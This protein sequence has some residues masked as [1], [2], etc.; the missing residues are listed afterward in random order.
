MC[1]FNPKND[2]SPQQLCVYQQLCLTLLSFPLYFRVN[3][4]VCNYL[5]NEGL[6]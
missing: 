6:V 3:D 2:L 5:Y 4:L 1:I